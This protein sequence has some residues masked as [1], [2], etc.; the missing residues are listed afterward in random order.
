MCHDTICATIAC[1]LAQ[2]YCY[3]R[4]GRVLLIRELAGNLELK[5]IE[6]QNRCNAVD[7]TFYDAIRSDIPSAGDTESCG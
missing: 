4:I 1:A 7:G 5:R 6:K 3:K 2:V